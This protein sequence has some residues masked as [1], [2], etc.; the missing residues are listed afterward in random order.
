[1]SQSL[2]E[3]QLRRPGPIPF[4][5]L[6]ERQIRSLNPTSTTSGEPADRGSLAPWISAIPLLAGL[7][8][9]YGPIGYN[10]GIALY[11]LNYTHG[12]VKRGLVGE[13]ILPIAHLSRTGI[14]ALQV[15]FILAAFAATYFV[16]RRLFFGSIADRTLAAVLFAAPALLP[17]LSFLFAQ[18]D[19]TLY[20][21]LLA[22]I[23]A[24]LQLPPIAGAFAATAIASVALLGHEAFSLAFYPLLAAI[25][26][27]R[28]RRRILPW[29]IALLQPLLVIIVF[30]IILHF[31]K[32]KVAPAVILADAANRTNVP[33]QPQVFEVMASTFAQQRALVSHFYAGGFFLLI[34]LTL[35]FSAPYFSLL[36]SLLRRATAPLQYRPLDGVILTLLFA[37]P[38]SLCYLGHDVSRWISACAIDA[39]L[40]LCYLALTSDAARASL[41]QWATGPRPFLWLAVLLIPGPYGATGIRLVEQASVLWS[42]Q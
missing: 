39:T 19:V 12:F 37:T 9:M 18:P 35:L 13:L 17:H 27:D 6:E 16:F 7:A 14:I 4:P 33:L 28:A 42:G 36:G 25:L 1:M 32:L 26:W 31:G 15:G 34:G 11:F 24:T 38:M 21:L 40:F 2:C 41:R 29:T 5:I 23:A 20:L 22:A 10:Y 3:S 8:S 30:A